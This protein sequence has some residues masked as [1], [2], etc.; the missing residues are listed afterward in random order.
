MAKRTPAQYLIITLKGI[1]MGAADVIPGVSGGTIAFI[2]GIYEELLGTI[3]GIKFGLLK[4]WKKEGFKA[5]WK[6]GNFSFLFSLLLGIGISIVSLAATITHLMTTYPI[7]VWSFFFGLVLA[8]IWLVGKT[9]DKWSLTN[10]I[11]LAAGTVGAYYITILSPTQGTEN[12][13]Y[14]FFCA[15]LAIC[16]MILPGISGS[17]VLLLLGAY[18]TVLGSIPTFIT[19]LKDGNWEVVSDRGILLGVFATGCIIGLIAFSKL[20]TWLYKKAEMLTIAILTGFLVGSLNKIWPWKET[21]EVFIKHKGEPN[22]EIVPLVER[23]VW[24]G[25]YEELYSK[26]HELVTAIPLMLFGLGLIL[27][28]EWIGNRMKAKRSR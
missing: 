27:V 24:P 3:A 20:L 15:V 4:I 10:I 6:Q 2:S 8:S 5:M 19:A 9:I 14:I 11:G 25:T 23:N 18:S 12:L 1:S 7:Q 16:A 28:L 22:E 17:F 13:V 21:V 26:P